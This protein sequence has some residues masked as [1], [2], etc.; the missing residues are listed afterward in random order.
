MAIVPEIGDTRPI[1]LHRIPFS[2]KENRHIEIRVIL[3]NP[4]ML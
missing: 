4:W 1:N 2:D 3:D